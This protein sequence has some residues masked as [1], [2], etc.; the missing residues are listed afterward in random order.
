M[1]ATAVGWSFA[2]DGCGQGTGPNALN[3]GH[4]ATNS[5]IYFDPD[6]QRSM[7]L[8]GCTA[9]S[10]HGDPG[11]PM[12]VVPL[13]LG[14]S[15]QDNFRAVRP[16]TANGSQSLL[17]TKPVY[18]VEVDHTGGKL[19]QVHDATYDRWL[20]WIN[21]GAPF[22]ADSANL[23]DA[24]LPDAA[25]PPPPQQSAEGGVACSLEQPVTMTSHNPGTECL[26]CHGTIADSRIRWTV[27]GTLFRDSFGAVP[28]AGATVQL[29]DA[30]NRT[31]LLVTDV[32][33]NFYTT[34]PVAFPLRAG[35]SLC[36]DAAAMAADVATGGCNAQ[37][38]HDNTL[39]MKLP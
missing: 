25:M 39:P 3:D 8:L 30:A 12:H 38:C 7:D 31:T 19:L 6:I 16:R 20:S 24:M 34:Q 18:G 2:V 14:G 5:A 10:C 35:A 1:A 36:P 17:L 33:G 15:T 13:M 27:A 28:R 37:R 26:G 21:A 11:N 29:V 32:Y 9:G 22:R 4:G 23:D